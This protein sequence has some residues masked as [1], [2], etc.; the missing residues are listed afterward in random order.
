MGVFPGNRRR[1][2]D[3]SVAAFMRCVR[4]RKDA[5]GLILWPARRGVVHGIWVGNAGHTS[6]GTV[7]FLETEWFAGW[8]AV[9]V[10]CGRGVDSGWC[11]RTTG[12]TIKERPSILLVYEDLSTGLRGKQVFDQLIQQLGSGTCFDLKVLKMVLLADD[13]VREQSIREG[14]EADIIVVSVNGHRELPAELN[15]WLLRVFSGEGRHPMALVA[16]LNRQ[17][18]DSRCANRILDDL[19]TISRVGGVEL[20]PH[21]AETHGGSSEARGREGGDQA[22]DGTPESGEEGGRS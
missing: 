19:W 13:G 6:S 4:S 14:A 7:F 3:S 2:K 15:E 20:L 22:G 9:A 1:P 12:E 10:V 16:S 21:F 8:G 17:A 5:R 18:R 11:Q